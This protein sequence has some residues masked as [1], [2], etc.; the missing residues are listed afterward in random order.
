MAL[1]DWIPE[2]IELEATPK[3]ARTI[4]VTDFAKKYDIDPSLYYYHMR[5][6]ENEK[7]VLEL[8]LSQAKKGTPEVLEK[9][10]EKAEQGN[11]KCIEMYLK[12]ILA[13]KD[14]VDIT[15]DEKPIPIFSALNSTKDVQL[16]NGNEKDTITK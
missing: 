8:S 4:S 7:K 15:T 14:R 11:E 3:Q 5:K 6:P 10:R 13:L 12:F 9:L 2:A 1:V 16:H